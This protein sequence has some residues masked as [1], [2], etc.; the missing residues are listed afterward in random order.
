M[1]YAALLAAAVLMLAGAVTAGATTIALSDLNSQVTIDLDAQTGMSSWVVD[2]YNH[3]NQQWFWYRIGDATAAAS[4]DT[5]TLD[6]F[7][8]FGGYGWAKY[9]GAGL[10]VEVDFFLLGGS[11]GTGESALLTSMYITN[12]SGQDMANFNL[13]QYADFDLSGTASDDTVHLD[14]GGP[15]L[16]T[17]QNDTLTKMSAET[18]DWHGVPYLYEAGVYD[19]TLNNLNSD[20]TDDLNK[21]PTASGNVTWAGQWKYADFPTGE[22]GMI[23]L[24]SFQEISPIPEP[25]TMLAVGM[26]IAGLAGYVRKRKLA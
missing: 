3:L 25:L 16:L 1:K 11:P 4:L 17:H 21:I 8:A 13:F 20:P 5:L 18:Y 23:E 7:S 6:G 19:D 26:G 10:E 12:T 15:E 24:H 2:G 14:G 9:Q 22:P